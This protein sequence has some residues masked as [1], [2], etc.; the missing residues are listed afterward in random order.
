MK[1]QKQ[2]LATSEQTL[3]WIKEKFV[4]PRRRAATIELARLEALHGRLVPKTIVDAARDRRSPL[5]TF[6]EWNDTVAA[7]KYRII[8]ATMLVRHVRVTIETPTMEAR[9][10]RAYVSPYHGGG[11]V[12]IERALSDADMRQ[13]LLAQ[14]REDLEAF[15]RRYEGFEELDQVFSAIDIVIKKPRKK[16]QKTA[17]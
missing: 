3:Q 15:K 6:F 9:E 13:A 1:A 12:R 16:R 5:H 14:A 4:G 7:Q 2:A 10:V 11:Y 17:A 8:Q